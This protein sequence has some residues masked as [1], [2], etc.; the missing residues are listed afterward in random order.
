MERLGLEPGVVGEKAQ[1]NPLS[2]GDTPS[3]PD[4]LQVCLIFFL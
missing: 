2:Y 3:S 1:M 4:L